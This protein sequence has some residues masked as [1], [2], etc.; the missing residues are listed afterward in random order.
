[1]ITDNLADFTSK[2]APEEVPYPD[3]QSLA[4][5]LRDPFIRRILPTAVR[6]PLHLEASSGTDNTFVADGSPVRARH[7][8]LN[9]VWG[10]YSAHGRATQG[11]FDSRSLP[12]CIAGQLLRFT[13]SGYLGRPHQYLAVK[14][15]VTGRDVPVVPWRAPGERWTAV[16]VP[17]PEHTFSVVAIDAEPESW[18]AFREPVVTA[19][20]SVAAEWLI[21]WSR[22]CF[23]AML[24]VAAL[25]LRWS[26]H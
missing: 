16:V 21:S 14:D 7:D 5:T 15:L 20:L 17:C 9:P 13:V 11:R 22:E 19:R 18:F 23:F 8:P 24:A 26:G 6:E 3:A 2:R 25:V 4:V 12:G 1:V 10:S